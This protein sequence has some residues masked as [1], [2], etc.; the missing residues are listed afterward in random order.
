[1]RYGWHVALF[2]MFLGLAAGTRKVTKATP[3]TKG[4]NGSVQAFDYGPIPPH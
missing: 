1:M 2:L 3:S 4:E